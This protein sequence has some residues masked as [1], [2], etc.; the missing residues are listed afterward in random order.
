[1]SVK[2][3]LVKLVI[4]L[5]PS[6]PSVVVQSDTLRV[7]SEAAHTAQRT[8]KRNFNS[9]RWNH[10]SQR[11]RELKVQ[12]SLDTFPDHR[13]PSLFSWKQS[14]IFQAHWW[15]RTVP[16]W[17]CWLLATTFG[18]WLNTMLGFAEKCV[19][20]VFFYDASTRILWA[21]YFQVVCTD[22]NLKY[23]IM[24]KT[25]LFFYLDFT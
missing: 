18:L 15:I 6:E 22:F 14:R 11:Q 10:P 5:C 17:F 4:R 3:T 2:K 25:T 8:T 7:G 19:R 12:Q 16:A 9:S 1:M 23:F 21:R 24:T 13:V 20:N